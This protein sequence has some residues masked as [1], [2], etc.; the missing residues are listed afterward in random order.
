MF[1]VI[2]L[3]CARGWRKLSIL[4]CIVQGYLESSL[5]TVFYRKPYGVGQRSSLQFQL[6][7]IKILPVFQWVFNLK[8][9][10]LL[11]RLQLYTAFVSC[12]Q[13]LALRTFLAE[14]VHWKIAELVHWKTLIYLPTF[15][16][17]HFHR[18]NL[19]NHSNLTRRN[20]RQEKA[21]RIELID[22]KLRL[23]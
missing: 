1:R 20:C 16:S 6:L 11:A 17:T 23:Q 12:S 15:S 9:V 13:N 8:W 21:P 10:I 4:W 3:N 18:D 5:I 14:L 22:K 2:I 19:R 7:K